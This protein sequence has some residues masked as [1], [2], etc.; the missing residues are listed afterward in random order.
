MR[1]FVSAPIIKRYDEFSLE[2]VD[3]K[4]VIISGLINEQ[5]TIE[6]GFGPEV[7]SISWLD[8]LLCKSLWIRG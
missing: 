2:T 3:G 7:C 5:R 1:V 4:C 8:K 6:N